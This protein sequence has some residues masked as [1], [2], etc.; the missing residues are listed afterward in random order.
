MRLAKCAALRERPADAVG[1]GAW[2]VTIDPRLIEE[3]SP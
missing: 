2:R 1:V 3:E